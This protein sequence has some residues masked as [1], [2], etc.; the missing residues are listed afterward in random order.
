MSNTSIIYPSC[1]PAIC[2]WTWICLWIWID[3]WAC[4]LWINQWTCT[5]WINQWVRVIWIDQLSNAIAIRWPMCKRGNR[6]GYQ[7]VPMTS[8]RCQT[9]HTQLLHVLYLW[10]LHTRQQINTSFFSKNYLHFSKNS[11]T[12]SAL[13]CVHDATF[14][15][16][17][18]H[19]QYRKSFN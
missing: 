11:W 17:L 9:L 15:T 16:N 18:K 8:R 4:V 19:L 13:C 1:F 14:T 6:V 3:R 12:K 10:A 5:I 2:I 7:I